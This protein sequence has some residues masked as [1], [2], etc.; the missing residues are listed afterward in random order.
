M[1]LTTATTPQGGNC[2]MTYNGTTGR[3]VMLVG[4]DANVVGSPQTWEWDGTSWTR[5]A[6]LPVP[7][8][9]TPIGL[10]SYYG[11]S[12]P[13]PLA[14]DPDISEVVAWVNTDPT[15]PG[16]LPTNEMWAWDGSTWARHQ[17]ANEP[18]I[19][20]GGF[21]YDDATGQ[22]VLLG[23]TVTNNETSVYAPP[24]SSTVIPTRVFGS[25][26]E[27]TAIAASAS[28]FPAAGSASAVVLA[29][30]DVFPDALAGGPLAA[31]KHAP[32][33]LT[34][35]GALD[36]STKAEISRVLP[37]GGTVYLL[38]GTSALSDA[39][40]AGVTAM[41]DVPLRISGPDRFATAV[42]IAD[43]LGD[44][45]TVF[46]A[47][48]VNFPDALSAVPA[49]VTTHGAILLTNG[50]S[51]AAATSTYLAKH[52]G[53]RYAIGGPAAWADPSATALAGATRYDTSAAVAEAFFPAATAASLADG[54]NFPDALAG[55]PLAGESGQPML[56]VNATGPIAEPI[57]A[58]LF[59][60]A[61]QLAAVRAF[62]GSAAVTA[63]SLD[64]AAR[65]L[66][67]TYFPQPF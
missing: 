62:G 3:I 57:A 50:Q 31:A 6:D 40:A 56:L 23:R 20:G 13:P 36:G 24:E 10:A 5:A 63:R 11:A 60:H 44:P 29:R 53:T 67:G 64:D 2:T 26:R 39:V 21:G 30:S 41:G 17:A 51:Q 45:T 8:N 37:T 65:V 59:T 35:P 7:V 19:G 9:R 25:D 42:A 47:S 12:E 28:A 52:P 18:S 1:Q 58:Y 61:G 34:S 14:F 46:E 15:S 49:A 27:S 66:A 55:G 16:G 48:G 32:L 33:L 54:D 22:L 4:S 43:A 38:G